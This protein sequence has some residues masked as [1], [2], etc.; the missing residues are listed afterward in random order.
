MI[1]TLTANPSVDRT[2][3][4]DVPFALGQVLRVASVRDDAGGKGLNVARAVFGAGLDVEAVLPAGPRDTVL[5][6]I[7]DAPGARLPYVAV[8]I[9]GRARTNITLVTPPDDTTK[10][11][12]PGPRLSLAEARALAEAVVAP[13]ASGDIVMLSGSLAPGLPDDFYV[14][15]V[16]ALHQRGAWVGV[17]TSDAPLAALA[18]ALSAGNGCA[19]DFMKPNS[20][21]L[22]QLTGGVADTWEADAAAGDVSALRQAA[23]A[24]RARGVAEVLVTLGGSGALLATASGA[25]Y[26]PTPH[27]SVASTVGAGDCAVGGYLIARAHGRPPVERLAWA[28]AYGAAAVALP[29]T[30]IP[31]PDD[32]HPDVAAVRHLE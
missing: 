1:R 31:T 16:R 22:A 4:L 14:G 19:P 13:T 27:V 25:W 32:V 10:I 7:D 21:E 15:L 29:G 30:G 23:Q 20:S 3:T 9:A 11:N 12:E 18:A 6:L 26:S 24:L 28:V 17:D 2:L 8:P 5:S